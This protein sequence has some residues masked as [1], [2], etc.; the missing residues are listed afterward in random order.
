MTIKD[1][2]KDHVLVTLMARGD[3]RCRVACKNVRFDVTEPY[4]YVQSEV[5]SYGVTDDCL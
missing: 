1:I 5:S 4:C 2:L 3:T